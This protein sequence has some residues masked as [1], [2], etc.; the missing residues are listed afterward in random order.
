MTLTTS[1]A[2]VAEWSQVAN[3]SIDP[4][5]P[6]VNSLSITL[7]DFNNLAHRDNDE[8]KLTY[9]IWWAAKSVAEDETGKWEFDENVDHS[10]IVGGGFLWPEYGVYVD[11][12]RFAV[13]EVNH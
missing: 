5:N 9:G 13:V 12:E 3:D 7:N 6:F 4:E 10:L 11:F 8:H 1:S 2:N